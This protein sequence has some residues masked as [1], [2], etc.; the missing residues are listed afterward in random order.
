MNGNIIDTV[1]YVAAVFT[2]IS[3]L[4]QVIKTMKSKETKD[5]SF[6]MYTFLIIGMLLW[7]VYGLLL[8]KNPIIYANGISLIFAGIVL[9]YKIKYK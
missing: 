3:V 8:E 2:T 6:G 7:F 1:G 5:I 9:G 4:P